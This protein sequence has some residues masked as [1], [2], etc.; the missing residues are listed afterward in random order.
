MAEDARP[1]YQTLYLSVR[2]PRMAIALPRIPDWKAG[3][4]RALENMS[5]VW[6]GAGHLQFTETLDRALDRTWFDVLNV[7]D[8]DYFGYYL[9]TFR[10]LQ[11]A[12]SRRVSAMGSPRRA[13]TNVHDV[14]DPPISAMPAPALGA[15]GHHR[16]GLR[17]AVRTAA[18]EGLPAGPRCSSR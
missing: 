2:P 11:I 12:G 9:P 7:Y 1:R 14:A 4:L 10:G 8:P 6:G 5:R 16:E 18:G 3:A 15:G 17:V 13:R